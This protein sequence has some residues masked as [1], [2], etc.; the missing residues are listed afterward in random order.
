[1]IPPF[2]LALIPL[3]GPMTAPHGGQEKI[4]HG[5]LVVENEHGERTPV[6][7][8][9]IRFWLGG[10]GG[11]FI[12]VEAHDGAFTAKL[13]YESGSLDVGPITIEGRPHWALSP[14]AIGAMPERADLVGSR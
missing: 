14:W 8:G 10:R 5:T 13:P 12:E 1:M 7:E 4:V 11:E 3:L 6:K 9:T 2:V